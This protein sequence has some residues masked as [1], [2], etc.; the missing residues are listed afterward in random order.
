MRQR[1]YRR[2]CLFLPLAAAMVNPT[3]LRHRGRWRA[4]GPR[5]LRAICRQSSKDSRKFSGSE[6]W[7]ERIWV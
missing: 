5:L 2:R 3:V 4:L 7:R 1:L 6:H